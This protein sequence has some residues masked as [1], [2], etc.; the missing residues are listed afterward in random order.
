MNQTASFTEPARQIP[1]MAE[2]D[3]V[4]CGGGAAGPA[5]AIAAAREGAKTLLVERDSHLGGTTVTSLVNVILSTNGVDFQGIWHEWASRLQTLGGIS[6][7]HWED[8]LG[9]RWLA[10]SSA[11][12]T[13]KLVWDQLLADAGADILHFALVAGAIVEDNC[14]RGVIVETKAGR[15]AILAKRVIDC[16]GDA[17]VCAAAGAGFDTGI[18]GKPW[19]Q[20]VTLNALVGGLKAPDKYLPGAT[21]RSAGTYP[22]FQRGLFR[23]L[24]IDPLNPWDLTRIVREARV[25]T[26]DQVEAMR[27]NLGCSAPS[28]GNQLTDGPF[29]SQTATYPG[30]RA[31]RRVHGIVT[32]TA[33]DAFELRKYPD[34]IARSSWEIDL[35]EAESATG[36][37]FD[38]NG[39]RM[40]MESPA[41]R[42]RQHKLKAGDWFDVRYGCLVARDVG[43]LMM[44]GRCISSDVV[45]HAS[46]RIQ[47]T[48][49]AMGQAAGTAA[50]MSVKADVT[51]DRL[52]VNQLTAR[53]DAIRAQTTP[54]FGDFSEIPVV[55]ASQTFTQ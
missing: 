12:E 7:L 31:S 44:A 15:Q 28:T 33:E 37:G 39:E 43:N 20:G 36:K 52:D 14:I 1:V 25:R 18:D 32:S 46:L 50:A 21:R 8:R 2:Y 40:D 27:K 10:G 17:D 19:T 5:A 55:E 54:A 13:V 23:F 38:Y 51:P 3:V 6:T 41:Y 24:R 53:L 9:T 47:Q 4:V 45:A 22:I 35:H 29:V 49:M 30:I 11:P 16:T 42:P 48:C 26:W 34:G